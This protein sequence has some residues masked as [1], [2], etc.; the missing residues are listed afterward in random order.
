MR[1]RGFLLA[2]AV[3]LGSSLASLGCLG[4]RQSK[5]DDQGQRRGDEK[6][7]L[8]KRLDVGDGKVW[9]R[10]I[11]VS[12]TRR[13]RPYVLADR[14]N[15]SVDLFDSRTPNSSVAFGTTV[16]RASPNHTFVSRASCSMR[17]GLVNNSHSGPD[18]VVIVDHKEIWAG[19]GD[20]KIK[21]IDIATGKFITTIETGD[22]S[23]KGR[24]DGL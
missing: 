24:R 1:T 11:S 3:S 7:V 13:S 21:V 18:G 14:T 8:T 4:G 9:A 6:L 10:S 16:P 12:S 22:P 15:A 19:D 5:G 23:P 2:S 20:S 17:T